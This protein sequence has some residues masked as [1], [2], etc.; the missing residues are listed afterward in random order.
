MSHDTQARPPRDPA[1]IDV[2]DERECRY[3]C[4]RFGVTSE[5]LREAVHQAGTARDDV[6]AYLATPA[7]GRTS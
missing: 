5:Q 3:W 2:E 6:L 1:R 4:E 7:T